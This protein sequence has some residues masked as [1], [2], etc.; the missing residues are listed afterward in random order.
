MKELLIEAKEKFERI[1]FGKEH[2][3][4]KLHPVESEGTRDF[5]SR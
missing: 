3:A 1:K 4:M 5:Y 2:P